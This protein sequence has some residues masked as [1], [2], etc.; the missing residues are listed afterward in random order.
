MV[1]LFLQ[2]A[3]AL[4]VLKSGAGFHMF[5]WLSTLASDFLAQGLVGATFFFDQETVT[6]KRWIFVNTVRHNTCLPRN[7]ISSAY[8]SAMIARYY[9]FLHSIHT[10]ALLSR[11][12]AVDHQALRLVLLQDYEC[13]WC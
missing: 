12:H 9:H 10:N 11:G 13:I 8:W 7:E 4:F 5:K 6:T 1:G 3:I 2:Q